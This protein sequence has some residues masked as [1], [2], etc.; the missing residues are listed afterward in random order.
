MELEEFFSHVGDT[1]C[2]G[3]SR[4]ST[5][6]T[7]GDCSSSIGS[8]SIA[9][10]HGPPGAGLTSLLLQ[11][12]FTQAKR[13]HSVLLVL[14]GSSGGD[15]DAESGAP[16]KP[17]LVPLTPCARCGVPA[18]T[19]G[20]S[21]VW[22]SIR[23]KCVSLRVALPVC[24]Y[25][26]VCAKKWT[27]AFAC[28]RRY[29]RSS[30]ELQHFLCSFHLMKEQSSVLLVDGLERFFG[31]DRFVAAS[32][33][34]TSRCHLTAACSF[35]GDVYQTLAY[36]YETLLF[37]QTSTG[38]GQVVVTGATNSF[39][40]QRAT[41][42]SLRRWCS[43]LSARDAGDGEFTLGEEDDEDDEEDDGDDVDDNGDDGGKRVQLRYEHLGPSARQRDG[44]F[45]LLR[46]ESLSY[47]S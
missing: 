4:D 35:L 33:L 3:A 2:S 24:V 21:L 28:A 18:Q 30:N 25:V 14:W 29:I 17:T 46:V 19:G 39:I 43:F 7:S 45:Q 23:I 42:R 40:L 47:R 12:G 38:S 37:M 15:R 9:F 22:S 8:D 36:L 6:D 13:G 27:H 31:S 34:I 44:S 10:L 5:S 1:R 41:R 32:L 26:C 20:D 11:F 16:S